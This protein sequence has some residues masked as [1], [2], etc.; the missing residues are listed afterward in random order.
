MSYL[1]Q[2]RR[3]HASKTKIYPSHVQRDLIGP[4]LVRKS[5]PCSIRS[6]NDVTYDDPS[7][8][9]SCD[10]L[11]SDF[12][13][14]SPTSELAQPLWPKFDVPLDTNEVAKAFE[15][16]LPN[17]WTQSFCNTPD[18]RLPSC[19]IVAAAKTHPQLSRARDRPSR[20]AMSFRNVR[21]NTRSFKS[22]RVSIESGSGSGAS[23]G[24]GK[25]VQSSTERRVVMNRNDSALWPKFDVPLDE[26]LASAAQE[27]LER[28]TLHNFCRNHECRLKFCFGSHEAGRNNAQNDCILQC[29]LCDYI[30]ADLTELEKHCSDVTCCTNYRSL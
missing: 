7:S 18:C 1:E 6:F 3:S 29:D 2:V 12:H 4:K 24:I 17:R 9:S 11:I 13:A 21:K 23:T 10:S 27:K 14:E 20:S 8:G 25:C 26:A 30:A 19:K 5:S 22:A 28:G 16:N 15:R